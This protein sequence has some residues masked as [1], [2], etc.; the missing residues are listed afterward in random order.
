MF[1]DGELVHDFGA[2]IGRVT[3]RL[4]ILG[5]K[6]KEEEIMR[7][8]PLALLPKFEQIAASIEMLLDLETIM[9]DELIGRLKPSEE[10]IN[11]NGGNTI[12]SQNLAEDELMGTTIIM[13]EGVRQ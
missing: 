5:F 4:A 11:C 6:Y 10:R 8:F 1:N 3:N 13:L 7:W 9:V 12:A 2:R